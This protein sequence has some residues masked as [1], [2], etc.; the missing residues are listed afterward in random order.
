[1]LH[2]RTKHKETGDHA[3]KRLFGVQS[4]ILFQSIIATEHTVYRLSTSVNLS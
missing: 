1:M 2:N 4:N 3:L